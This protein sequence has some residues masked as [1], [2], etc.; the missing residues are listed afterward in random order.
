MT[1]IIRRATS[2]VPKNDGVS[3]PSVLATRAI[4]PNR[5]SNIDLPTIQDTATGE[6]IRGSRNATRKNLR[7]RISALSRSARP[8]AMTYSTAIAAT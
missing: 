4:G 5:G 7:A 8:K 3:Q 2:G 6:S 1:M